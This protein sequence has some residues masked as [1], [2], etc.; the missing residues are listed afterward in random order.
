M[1]PGPSGA[2]V[3]GLAAFV[4][5]VLALCC[6]AIALGEYPPV[7]RLRLNRLGAV[8]LA[9]VCANEDSRPLR[10]HG[11]GGGTDGQPTSDCAAIA[12]TV[13][14]YARSRGVGH[15]RALRELAPHVTGLRPPTTRRHALYGA[16]PASGR[17]RPDGWTTARDGDWQVHGR[18]WETMRERV[19]WDAAHGFPAECPADPIAWGGDM[20][21][22]I[23]RSRRLARLPCGEV[24]HFWSRTLPAA[25]IAAR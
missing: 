17:A 3:L 25:M 22:G 8:M 9:R 15:L 18:L 19:V 10:R 2:Q 6:H 12:Q 24:N 16:L 5:A 21:D 1:R 20:D 4:L 14:G 11:D 7:V 13:R 23:A